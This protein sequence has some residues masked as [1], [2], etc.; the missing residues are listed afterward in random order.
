LE[1]NRSLPPEAGFMGIVTL[2]D[3]MESLLQDRIYDESDIR[4]RDR[5]VAT[6]QSWAAT[7]VIYS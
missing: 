3:I 5:A 2:E 4:D 7:A 6:L 1:V